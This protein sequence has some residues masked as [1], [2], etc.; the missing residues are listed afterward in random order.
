MEKELTTLTYLLVF[1]LPPVL[2]AVLAA[3]LTALLLHKSGSRLAEK[4]R[5][6]MRDAKAT[7]MCTEILVNIRTLNT[8]LWAGKGHW[9]N[10]GN[11]PFFKITHDLPKCQCCQSFLDSL[12]TFNL[13]SDVQA[14]LSLILDYIGSVKSLHT[15]CNFPHAVDDIAFLTR[16]TLEMRVCIIQQS[17]ILLEKIKDFWPK[18]ASLTLPRQ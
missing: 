5:S 6:Q 12:H 7:L 13:S 3:M 15:L 16:I 1:V 2:A 10:W 11:K 18:A 14:A 4:Q 8:E 9:I 17:D